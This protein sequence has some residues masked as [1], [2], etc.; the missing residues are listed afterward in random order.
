MP[1]DQ[2]RELRTELARKIALFMGS[3]ASRPHR[4]LTVAALQDQATPTEPRP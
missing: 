3:E 1:T 2:A 4:S